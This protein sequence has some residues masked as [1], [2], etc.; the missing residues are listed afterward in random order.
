MRLLTEEEMAFVAGG[1][2]GEGG[3]PDFGAVAAAQALAQSQCGSSNVA[4]V[5]VK[6]DGSVTIK[7]S[8]NA[9]GKD[10]DND[11]ES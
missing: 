5:T 9:S 8:K 11:D 7:C 4:E 1:A 6:A 10:D 2:E 3:S